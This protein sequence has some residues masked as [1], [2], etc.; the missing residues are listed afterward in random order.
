M[1]G[2]ALERVGIV[3]C[4]GKEVDEACE[5]VAVWDYTATTA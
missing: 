1:A 4:N 5:R 2:A 3:V